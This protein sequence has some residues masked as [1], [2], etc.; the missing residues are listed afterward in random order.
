MI[1]KLYQILDGREEW[2]YDKQPAYIWREEKL[3]K[4]DNIT[5]FIKFPQYN[6]DSL[7]SVFREIQKFA[8]NADED[9]DIVTLIRNSS[10]KY[11][12]VLS[13]RHLSP[14]NRNRKER[15]ARYI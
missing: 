7:C 12:L 14:T 1:R 9:F 10:N 4:V 8:E 5:D 2:E 3:D 6:F 15:K 11:C 13:D